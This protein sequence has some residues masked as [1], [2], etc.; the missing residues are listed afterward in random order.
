MAYISN[1]CASAYFLCPMLMMGPPF[2]RISVMRAVGQ[3]MPKPPY[4]VLR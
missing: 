2:L 3:V 1:A 4:I